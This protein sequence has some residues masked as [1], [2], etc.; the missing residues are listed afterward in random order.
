MVNTS[1]TSHS[2]HFAVV[3]V[4]YKLHFLS[5]FQ[6]YGAVR[7]AVVTQLFLGLYS[8]SD[9]WRLVPLDQ[10]FPQAALIPSAPVTTT[11]SVL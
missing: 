7:L 11:H 8:T 10:P 5:Y 4:R 2:Y 9:R 1:F 3:V 6:V